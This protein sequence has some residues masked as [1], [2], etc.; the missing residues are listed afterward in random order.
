[1]IAMFKIE[2]GIPIPQR[3]FTKVYPF[4]DLAVGQSFLVPTDEASK[5]R[6]RVSSAANMHGKKHNSRFATRIVEGG[7]R[8][9]RV[10]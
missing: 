10:K 5:K 4:G 1:M 7:V 2:D 3:G 8:V 6:A 9:W